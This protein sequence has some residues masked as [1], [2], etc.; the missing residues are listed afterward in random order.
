MSYHSKKSFAQRFSGLILVAG[1]HIGALVGLMVGLSPKNDHVVIENVKVETV[2][3]VQEQVEAP[4]PPPPDYV[5]PP[6]DFVPPPDFNVAADAPAPANAITTTQT[7]PAEPA[8][9]PVAV[10]STPAKLPKKFTG[11]DPNK[12]PKNALRLNQEGSASLQLY[13]SEEG[14]VQ[15][16]KLAA[17]SG[18]PELDEY[19]VSEARK[20]KKFT[21]CMEG[22]KPKA[23]WFNL[24]I[25]MKVPK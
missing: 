11:P 6:P 9:A 12:Y 2:E 5:P 1:L 14:A 18:V 3:E 25:T 7:K 24:K 19:A 22:D 4:P 10:A 21:P 23:C 17:S 15:D 20:W 8:P 13:I 16:V